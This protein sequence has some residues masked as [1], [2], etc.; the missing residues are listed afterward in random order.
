MSC[1]NCAARFQCFSKFNMHLREFRKKICRFC[2]EILDISAFV[3]H[4][5]KV[6]NLA[7]FSCPICLESFEKETA[8]A[9]HK[10]KHEKGPAECLECHE[11]FANSGHLNK[12][13][14]IKH[15]P[16]IC[17]CGKKLPNRVCFTKHKKICI[18]H[19][20][21]NQKFICDYCKVEYHKKNC[22]KM[23]IKLRHTVGWVFQCHTCGKKFASR[24]HLT[25][26]ETTHEKITDRHVCYCGAKYSSRRGYERH[27][28]RH[29]EAKKLRPNKRIK[30]KPNALKN[31]EVW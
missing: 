8:L 15:K 2:Y 16:M 26:H 27:L 25:E 9:S 12:H 30:F 10:L 28:K 7:L 24:A 23:H 13:M 19:N 3:R 14:N 6:H 11:T 31:A 20:D 17:G 4:S 21:M 5:A 29:T 1:P 22:L 18:K